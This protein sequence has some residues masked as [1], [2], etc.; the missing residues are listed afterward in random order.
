MDTHQNM[1]TDSCAYTPCSSLAC[2]KC[3]RPHFLLLLCLLLLLRVIIG[4]ATVCVC[5]DPRWP[6]ALR[7]LA[8]DA[9]IV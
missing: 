8:Y 5:L 6:L 7:Y 9:Q 3:S 1:F 2:T 4:D